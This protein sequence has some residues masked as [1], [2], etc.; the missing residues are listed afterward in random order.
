MDQAGGHRGL[1]KRCQAP[2]S[3]SQSQPRPR[4]AC[5]VHDHG[6]L[7][8]DATT[9][10]ADGRRRTF[11]AVFFRIS[12]PCVCP[13]SPL[14]F[15]TRMS[16]GWPSITRLDSDAAR[17]FPA[18]GPADNPGTLSHLAVLLTCDRRDDVR[19]NRMTA[20][21]TSASRLRVRGVLGTQSRRNLWS[22]RICSASTSGPEAQKLV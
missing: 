11:R 20:R 13:S 12:A 10:A 18:G 16:D 1:L 22:S 19:V 7:P 8:H 5:H 4:P 17:S 21:R 15:P 3:Q 2:Q 9:V 6:G 14:A